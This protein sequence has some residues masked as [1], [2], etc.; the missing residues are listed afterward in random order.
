MWTIGMILEWLMALETMKRRIWEVV[1]STP[2]RPRK[3]G[4]FIQEISTASPFEVVFQIV[5]N[6][7]YEL[8]P[9]NCVAT[10]RVL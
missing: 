5:K 4:F 10:W 7:Q 2:G 6:F 8:K 9:V 3:G 1:T